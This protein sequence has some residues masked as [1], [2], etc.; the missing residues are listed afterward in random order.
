[1]PTTDDIRAAIANGDAKLAQ[2]LY[3]EVLAKNE[4]A[5]LS[6][7]D[8]QLLSEEIAGLKHSNREEGPRSGGPV[9]HSGGGT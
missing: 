1:M 7:H 3:D 9:R 2:K 8:Q 6:G 5:G 4:G